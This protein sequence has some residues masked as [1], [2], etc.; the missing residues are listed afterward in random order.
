MNVRVLPTLCSSEWD[1]GSAFKY[2]PFFEKCFV[3]TDSKGPSGPERF[4]YYYY[5]VAVV[6]VILVRCWRMIAD[7]LNGARVDSRIIKVDHVSD[8]KRKLEEDEEEKQRKR[9]E[10]GVCYAFQRGECKRGDD[11]KFSH[12]EQ[13]YYTQQSDAHFCYYNPCFQRSIVEL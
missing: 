4:Y 2:P 9:E 12:D 8:Y 6:V 1:F 11:C 5:F 3:N 7:N 13:V 10:R